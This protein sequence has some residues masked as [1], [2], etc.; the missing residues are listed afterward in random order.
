MHIYIYDNY[1]NTAEHQRLLAKIETRITDLGLNGKIIRLGLL[2]NITGAIDHEVRRG[3]K[4]LVAVGNNQTLHQIVNA[5][6]KSNQ[7]NN[8][9]IPIGLI[10]IGS[11]NNEIAKCFGIPEGVEACDLLSARRI[12]TIDLGLANDNNFITQAS[13][14]NTGTKIE[15]NQD[16]SIE[17]NKPGSINIVNIP[18]YPETFP[19]QAKTAPD[20]NKLELFIESKGGN[21]LKNKLDQSV[22]SFNT[23][24]IQNEKEELLLDNF[25]KIKT[26]VLVRASDNKMNFI[27][28][29]KRNF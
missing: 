4:T 13:I 10:P 9:N 26:P 2:K 8:D 15:I 20:D 25:I 29:K 18:L 6:I 17:I 3:V 1:V 28:G 22:F 19:P 14:S 5:L 12:Q 21:F 7:H 23:I 16:Y 24:Q 11:Q 27:V